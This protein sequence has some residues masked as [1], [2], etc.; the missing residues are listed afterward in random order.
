MKEIIIDKKSDVPNRLLPLTEAQQGLLL[1]SGYCFVWD[2][3]IN[4]GREIKFR[5]ESVGFE[6]EN[7]RGW[8]EPTDD[9]DLRADPN[10]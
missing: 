1:N 10:E 8:T 4:A 2:E 5:G 3:E 7:Q 9:A 6:R